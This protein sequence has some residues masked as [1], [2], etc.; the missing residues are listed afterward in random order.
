MPPLTR[1]LH[2]PSLAAAALLTALVASLIAYGTLTPPGVAGPALPLTDKQLH[3]LAFAGLVLPLGWVRPGW[4]LGIALTA[5]A[6]GG[7]IELVQPWTGRAAEWADFVADALGCL[8][9][10]MPGQI[11]RGLSGQPPR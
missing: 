2:R 5:V 3:A 11:R 9:G 6:F 4:A 8:I 7:L 1:I 10:L